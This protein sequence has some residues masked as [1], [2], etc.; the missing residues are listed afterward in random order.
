MF[1]FLRSLGLKPLEWDEMRSLTG[2]PTPYIGEILRAGF[3]YAQAVV[4]LLT[5]DDYAYLQEIF[6]RPDD[7]A[8]ERIGSPQPRPNVL[9]EAGVAF[10][11]QE[12]A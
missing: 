12:D 6:C 7:S 2:K 11:M 8:E 4:V 5:G 3:N 10:G 1:R 9:F